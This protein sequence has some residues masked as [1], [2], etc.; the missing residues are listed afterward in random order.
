MSIG[1]FKHTENGEDILAQ[2]KKYFLDDY[3]SLLLTVIIVLIT[4]KTEN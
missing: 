1:H 3:E 4:L 2:L